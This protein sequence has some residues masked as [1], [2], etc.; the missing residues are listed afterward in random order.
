MQLKAGVCLY[1]LMGCTAKNGIFLQ[2]SMLSE[3]SSVTCI[4]TIAADAV[5]LQDKQPQLGVMTRALRL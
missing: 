2:G 1:I 3:S 5:W 4:Q